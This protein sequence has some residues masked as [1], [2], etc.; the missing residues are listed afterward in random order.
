MLYI[1]GRFQR[2]AGNDLPRLARAS[3]LDGRI[4]GAWR[5]APETTPPH[6]PFALAVGGDGAF[7]G[8]R[9]A[10]VAGQPVRGLARIGLRIAAADPLWR[11]LDEDADLPAL[12][13]GPRGTVLAAWTSTAG[14]ATGVRLLAA[15]PGR[16]P[17]QVGAVLQ[18]DVRDGYYERL[19]PLGDGRTLWTGIFRSVDGELRTGIALLRE[20]DAA[21]TF[22]DGFEPR[23]D[24]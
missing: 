12:A 5:P 23:L 22:G 10:A 18:S 15:L 7:I 17:A 3:A 9:L 2:I 11:P 8:G 19:L 24:R 6:E 4:D 21:A 14:S 13:V 1:G 16:A 20:G